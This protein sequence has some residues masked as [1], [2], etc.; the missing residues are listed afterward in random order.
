LALFITKNLQK[1]CVAFYLYVL[2][3]G[4]IKHFSTLRL[5]T[6]CGLDLL[7]P[8]SSLWASSCTMK[9]SF[10]DPDSLISLRLSD[11]L[12]AMA[13][14]VV[15]AAAHEDHAIADTPRST[16]TPSIAAS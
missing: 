14:R 16:A 1:D 8:K 3:K 12:L 4:V 13:D 15:S 10:G 2:M 11:H 9:V 5:P 6:L 7:I